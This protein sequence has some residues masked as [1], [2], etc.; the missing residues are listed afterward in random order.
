M[1]LKQVSFYVTGKVQNVMFRQT[2]IR[3]AKN[4]KLKGGASNDAKNH[5]LV[6][7]S[8][9]GDDAIID[10]LIHQLKTVQP[11]N[12]WGAAVQGLQFYDNFIEFS[13]HQVTTDNVS[14]FNWAPDVIFYL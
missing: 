14:G 11:L 13:N 9:E 4:R 3:A 6:H 2:F 5:Q 8:L 7:C 12:S 10:E 1:I